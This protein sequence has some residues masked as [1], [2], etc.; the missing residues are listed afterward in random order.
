[1]PRGTVLNSSEKVSIMLLHKKNFSNRAIAKE[2][3]RSPK[4]INNYLSNP[5]LYNKKKSRGR[6]TI[7]NTRLKRL[8]IRKASCENLS[9]RQ[10]SM[11]LKNKISISTVNR[12][13][14]KSKKLKYMKKKPSPLLTRQHKANRL[15]W[16]ERYLRWQHDWRIVIWSDEKKFNLDGPDGLQYYW[17]DLRKEKL[18]SIKRASGGGSVFVWAAFG[19]YSK[20]ELCFFEKLNAAT[21]KEIL[22]KYLL[23]MNRIELGYDW[24]FQQDNAPVHLAKNILSWF[25]KKKIQLLGWPP[26]SPDLNPMENVWGILARRVYN[27]G[28][29]YYNKEELK[30]SILYEWNKLKMNELKKIIDT[31]PSRVFDV[32]CKGGGKIQY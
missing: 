30:K 12:V 4:V 20:S 13:I 8:I 9:C 7:V 26:L 14:N 5:K 25:E 3:G 10:I 15:N 16:A 2:L 32:L 31:M 24:Y 11:E 29:Q 27:N 18:V 17:H 23:S 28:K 6:K 21:Y 19:Y 22:Q 1:M